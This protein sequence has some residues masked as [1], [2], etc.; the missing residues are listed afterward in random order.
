MG[1][2]NYDTIGAKLNNDIMDKSKLNAYFQSCHAPIYF[3]DNR[4]L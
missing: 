1:L 3:I 2:K 4:N